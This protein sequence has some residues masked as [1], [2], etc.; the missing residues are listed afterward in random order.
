[1]RKLTEDVPIFPLSTVLFPDGL[2]SLRIFEPRYLDMVSYCLKHDAPFGVCMIVEGDEVGKA[3]HSYRLGTLAK[4]VNWDKAD[5]GV[6]SIDVMGCQRFKL[7]ESKVQADQLVKA[8]IQLLETALPIEIPDEIKPL[9]KTLE[10]F[11]NSKQT[12]IS[13]DKNQLEDATWLS[14][15]L[16]EILPLENILRQKLLELDDPIERLQIILGVFADREYIG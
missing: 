13:Y 7:I 5:D 4:I 6:L 9:R 3:A 8:K 14:F 15:R 10:K 12:T 16:S 11:L 1:M 2:L